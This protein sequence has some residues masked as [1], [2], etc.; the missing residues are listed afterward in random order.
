M[1]HDTSTVCVHKRIIF[2]T[3]I[4]PH[5]AGRSAHGLEGSRRYA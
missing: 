4:S 5:S 2:N 1:L 3:V